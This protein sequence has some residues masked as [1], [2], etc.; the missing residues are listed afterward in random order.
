MG[1]I[2]MGIKN[3]NISFSKRL[4]FKEDLINAVNDLREAEKSKKTDTY[5]TKRGKI[6]KML[7]VYGIECNKSMTAKQY[8]KILKDSKIPSISTLPD[9]CWSEMIE[10]YKNYKHPKDYMERLVNNLAAPEYNIVN[11]SIRLKILKQLLG[12]LN[13]LKG[14]RFYDKNLE[15]VILEEYNGDI[16]AIDEKIFEKYMLPGHINRPEVLLEGV[17][18]GYSD[19]LY[20]P[21]E[22][23]EHL[24]SMVSGYDASLA[25]KKAVDILKYVYEKNHKD[26]NS[27]KSYYEINEE[28]PQL[29]NALCSYLDDRR[30]TVRDNLDETKEK[31]VALK[32]NRPEQFYAIK[33]VYN[34]SI[35]KFDFLN[36]DFI[37]FIEEHIDL[38]LEEKLSESDIL[39]QIEKACADNPKKFA[40]INEYLI[41]CFRKYISAKKAVFEDLKEKSR[42]ATKAFALLQ[43]CNELAEGKFQYKA[44]EMKE[45]LYIFAFAFDMTVNTGVNT[46]KY[47]YKRDIKK[48]L[49]ED[50]YCDNV[51]RYI[52]DAQTDGG[53]EEPIGLTIQYKNFVEIVYLY[54]LNKETTDDL[55][56]YLKLTK[57]TEMIIKIIKEY[58]ASEKKKETLKEGGKKY[59]R[60]VEIS[61]RKD[62]ITIA[63]RNFFEGNDKNYENYGAMNLAVG[64]LLG[65]DEAEFKEFILKHYNFDNVTYY[66]G[67]IYNNAFENESEQNSAE[68]I[69]DHLLKKIAQVDRREDNLHVHHCYG[70]Q[71]FNKHIFEDSDNVYENEFDKAVEKIDDMILNIGDDYTNVTRTKL[72]ILHYIDFIQEN[73]SNK[74][75]DSFADFLYEYKDSL[76]DL[77]NEC[78]YQFFSSKNLL[79]VLLA[80]SAF[81]NL[82]SNQKKK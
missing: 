65:K 49:F 62:V 23:D 31:L 76:N 4:V 25:D 63:Y 73:K 20:S 55:T 33:D 8:E 42:K 46:V 1:A 10:I 58:K 80:Y 39:S 35:F 66:D 45:L 53:A 15:T 57:A 71:F 24:A 41:S 36:D 75:S 37:A 61:E 38:E 21:E 64:E 32:K 5:H 52:N 34:N 44:S 81:I 43:I 68:N 50:F 2:T 40:K 59:I 60:A 56:C 67:M 18:S 69:Y 77:F 6:N 19:V 72:M 27:G 30:I 47:D 78:S 22:Y 16:T 70:L 26:R 9:F 29:I 7:K 12:N 54:W 14:T 17:L 74:Y 79:D 51:I 82:R 11:T 13:Y 48:N 3:A 28:Q